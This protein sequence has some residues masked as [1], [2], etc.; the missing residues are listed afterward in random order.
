MRDKQQVF[1]YAGY[2]MRSHSETRWAALMD[3]ISIS[4][5]YESQLIKTRHGYYLPDFYL[6]AVGLFVEVKGLGPTAVEIEKAEDAEAAT[7]IPVIFAYGKPELLG[8][9]LAHGVVA[10][11]N[12]AK[13]ISFSTR[14]LGALVRQSY[15]IHTYSAFICAGE[16]QGMPDSFSASDVM[17]EWVNKSMDRSGRESYA[18]SLHGPLNQA[19]QDKH[20]Q[21]S[22]AEWFLAK[23]AEK[24][25][26]RRKTSGRENYD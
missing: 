4:W 23:F 6:P 13:R 5:L 17:L 3:S 10:Y 18:A 16:H 12:G 22:K 21:Q 20:G 2:E 1:G 19:K 15:D 25:R 8:A 14:E 11:F 24:V 26:S 7:G 9:E